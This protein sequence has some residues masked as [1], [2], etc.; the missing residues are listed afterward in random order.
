MKN[1]A[2]PI[3]LLCLLFSI[4]TGVITGTVF[5]ELTKYWL[6]N[7]VYRTEADH[8]NPEHEGKL[9]SVCGPLTTEETLTHADLRVQAIDISDFYSVARAGQLQLGARRVEGLFCNNNNPFGY[10]Y[11]KP[12][13]VHH[14]LPDGKNLH[15]LPSGTRVILLG[16][17]RGDVLDMRDSA[18]RA[19]LGNDYATW[20]NDRAYPVRASVDTRITMGLCILLYY[21]LW[22][23]IV[24]CATR[25]YNNRA[26]RNVRLRCGLLWGVSAGSIV[27]LLTIAFFHFL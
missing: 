16:R 27:L 5:C 21:A 4:P 2:L 24:V 10:Y 9:V 6:S 7:K 25:L 26:D 1:F 20:L 15:Y 12:E 18:A 8:I 14:A 13:S 19:V 17:Q 3:L 23:G 11:H 22:W